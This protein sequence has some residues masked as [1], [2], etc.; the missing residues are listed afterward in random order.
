MSKKIFLSHAKSD[1]ENAAAKAKAEQIS[2]DELVLCSVKELNRLLKGLPKEE[3]NKLKQRRRTLKNRGYAANCREKR[4]SQKEELEGDREQL[5]SEVDRLT[6]ENDVV[7]MEL[8]SLK[9]KFDALRRFAEAKNIKV[10]PQP[11][12]MSSPIPPPPAH[13]NS[14]F[15]KS[16][17]AL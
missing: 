7:K 1:S 14:V 9:N 12:I 5:R 16:E 8:T 10:L 13:D 17:H 4:I 11:M 3:V 6:R 15:M 2:D